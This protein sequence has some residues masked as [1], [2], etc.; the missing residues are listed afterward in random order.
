MKLLEKYFKNQTGK[1]NNRIFDRDVSKV[2]DGI[3]VGSIKRGCKSYSD[4]GHAF[5]VQF[6]NENI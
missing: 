2:V 4:N 5:C 3:E 6:V 1:K